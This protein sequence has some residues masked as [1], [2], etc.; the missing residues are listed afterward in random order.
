MSRRHFLAATTVAAASI[1]AW[2]PALAQGV[3]KIGEVNSYKAQPA[4]LE[5]YK[6]G[7]ELAVAEINARLGF[8]LPASFVEGTLGIPRAGTA[9][10]AL[11]FR[12]SQWPAI[13]AALVRHVQ[14]A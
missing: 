2:A 3:I 5:P 1:A 10:P 13:K 11:L 4:F 7:M 14:A 8:N 9:G 6:K 12:E